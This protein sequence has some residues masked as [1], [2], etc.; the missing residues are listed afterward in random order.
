VNLDVVSDSEIG[1]VAAHRRCVDVIKLLHDVSLSAFASGRL[2]EFSVAMPHVDAPPK[3]R[4]RESR[5]A[6]STKTYLAI[7]RPRLPI[8]VERLTRK[9]HQS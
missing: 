8:R 4:T 3:Q 6:S 7:C 2:R 9:G 5:C 1:D